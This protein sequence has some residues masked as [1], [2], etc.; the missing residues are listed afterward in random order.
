[1]I[2]GKGP[3]L[4][5]I[6][7]LAALALVSAALV[8]VLRWQA[9]MAP[10]SHSDLDLPGLFSAGEKLP[11][12]EGEVGGIPVLCYHYF[13]PGFNLE[14]MARILAALLLNM[15][16]IPDKDFW[17]ISETEFE[18]H[19]RYLHEHGF[20]TAS[21]EELSLH[22]EGVRPLPPRS[23]VLTVDDG[24][25]SFHRIAAPILRKY[26]QRATVFMLTGYAGVPD[27]NDLRFMDAQMLRDLESSG[28][29]RVESHTHRM[30]TK[31]RVRGRPIPRFLL[32]SRDPQG[33][34]STSSPLGRDLL[35][36][37]DWIRRELGHD[38]EFLSWPFGFG[39]ASTES[40]AV[41]VGFRKLFTL[42]RETAPA[43]ASPEVLNVGRFAVT[44]R[45]SFRTFQ[46]VVEGTW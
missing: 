37:R 21:M 32:E 14:R 33:L 41:A 13:R 38:A 1:M 23:V 34:I 31:V 22:L 44:A 30:H 42:R 10:S 3:S 35:T 4:S 27:W 36:S 17:S 16:T 29:A 6:A 12:P 8:L 20:N 40:L 7:L 43:A 24:D 19:M 15:P 18:K 2:R 39:D 11:L 28:V 25:E 46:R 26:N 9:R 5:T 45:T